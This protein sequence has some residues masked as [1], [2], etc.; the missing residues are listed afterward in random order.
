[1]L[2][3]RIQFSYVHVTP[4]RVHFGLIPCI[5]SSKITSRQSHLV[6]VTGKLICMSKAKYRC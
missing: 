6:Q 3:W 5:S 2:P 4:I 1:M